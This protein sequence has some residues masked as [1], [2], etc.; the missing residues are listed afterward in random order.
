MNAGD[1]CVRM[2]LYVPLAMVG[3]FVNSVVVFILTIPSILASNGMWIL[4]VLSAVQAECSLFASCLFL[5]TLPVYTSCL[6]ILL[7]PLF[8]HFLF[9]LPV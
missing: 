6:H 9:L 4:L 1:T 8:T 7:T 2:Y 5:F 3:D